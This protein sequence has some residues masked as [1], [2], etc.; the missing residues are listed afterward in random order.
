MK[1]AENKTVNWEAFESWVR[2]DHRER[3]AREIVSYAKRYAHCLLK[4]D[5]TE[6]ACL[7]RTLRTHVIKALSNLS[8]FLGVYEEYK[9]LIRSYGIGWTGKSVDDLVIERLTKV[10]NPDEV[11]QWVK[12][13]KTVRPDLAEF[14]D[15]IS[16]SGLRLNEAV[17]SFNL[18]IT[19]SREGKLSE[20]Y[21]EQTE[22][23]EHFRFKETFI[24]R[25]KKAFVSFVPKQLIQKITLCSTLKSKDAV[26]KRVHKEGLSV[27]FSDIREAHATLL[28][29]YLKQPEID[30]IHGRVSANVFMS[31]YF[32]PAMISDLKQRVFQ[33]I[34]EIQS[35][36]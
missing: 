24:R 5:L 6:V 3:V 17:E 36:I 20:Y 25:T 33:A 7:R 22:A 4:R 27:R 15:F 10:K 2:K 8:K 34:A 28:T 18:V 30:F 19:L 29:K 13:V 11:F 32:N 9:R 1:K 23:L 35:K 21:N 31:N 26:Q 14:M 12:Q 16:V